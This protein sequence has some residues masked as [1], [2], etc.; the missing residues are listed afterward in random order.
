MIGN[1]NVSQC[2]PCSRGKWC[3]PG[4]KLFI[5]RDC[6]AGYICVR[7]AC[8]FGISYKIESNLLDKRVE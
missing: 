8:T 6:D 7:G 1:K 3:D 2:N 4:D 5:E